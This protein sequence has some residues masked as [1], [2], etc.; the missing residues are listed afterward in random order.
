MEREGARGEKE[1]NG[2]RERGG[3]KRGEGEDGEEGEGKREEGTET[4]DIKEEAEGSDCSKFFL[5]FA[6]GPS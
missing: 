1:G 6:N 3:G 4:T 2:G 5:W